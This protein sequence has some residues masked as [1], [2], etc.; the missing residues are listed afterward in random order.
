M[1]ILC[2]FAFSALALLGATVGERAAAATG[3]SAVSW[4]EIASWELGPDGLGEIRIGMTVG[5]VERATGRSMVRGEYGFPTCQP[6]TLEGAPS[7]LGITTDGGK[8]ARIDIGNRRWTTT[9]GIRIG[10]RAGKVKHRYGVETRPHEYT[11]GHYLVTR[12]KHRL[13]FETSSSG[14][15]TRFRAG[16]RPHVEYV[17]GC[18]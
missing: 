18:A 7:G 4:Q 10:D 8:V 3:P 13:V 14:K 9:R 17:E 5:A 16:R 2:A 15:V 11:R 6:W 12:G 1:R